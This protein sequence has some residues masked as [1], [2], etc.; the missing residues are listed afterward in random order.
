MS[1]GWEGMGHGGAGAR[2]QPGGSRS[3]C[4]PHSRL[5]LSSLQRKHRACE[6]M[7][8]VN[9]W[10]LVHSWLCYIYLVPVLCFLSVFFLSPLTPGLSLLLPT[11]C[12]CRSRVEGGLRGFIFAFFLSFTRPGHASGVLSSAF[13]QS[14]SPTCMSSSVLLWLLGKSW[15]H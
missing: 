3:P 10:F 6:C 7:S 8:A 5:A 12:G 4:R 2:P 1:L 9:K 14:F 13:S 15:S 11:W